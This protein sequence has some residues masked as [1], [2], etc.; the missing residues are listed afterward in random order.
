MGLT[1]VATGLWSGLLPLLSGLLHLGPEARHA[2]TDSL[3]AGGE[4]L[5]ELFPALSHPFVEVE[6]RDRLRDAALDVFDIQA[7]GGRVAGFGDV[8]DAVFFR[9]SVEEG[10][11]VRLPPHR[12][13]FRVEVVG[14]V[15]WVWVVFGVAYAGGDV[16]FRH[17]LV[18]HLVCHGAEER[19]DVF[20]ELETDR[21]LGPGEAHVL[22][23][24]GVLGIP[25]VEDRLGESVDPSAVRRREGQRGAERRRGDGDTVGFV[26]VDENVGIAFFLLQ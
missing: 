7:S 11:V 19:Q 20:F 23:P 22:R 9:Q 6:F 18:V 14:G 3:L 15:G 10:K 2:G 21:V 26:E 8:E 13:V 5:A 1:W 12:Q 17:G 25:R 24:G 4:R 16:G